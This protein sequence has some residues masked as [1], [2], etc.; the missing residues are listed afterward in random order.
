MK[1]V[2]AS[3]C[4][5]ALLAGCSAQP[6]AQSKEEARPPVTGSAQLTIESRG[7]THVFDVQVAN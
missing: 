1:A 2:L 3:L 6:T 4:A 5:M 7:R